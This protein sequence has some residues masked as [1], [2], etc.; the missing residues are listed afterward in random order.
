MPAHRRRLLPTLLAAGNLSGHLTVGGS[1]TSGSI[2]NTLAGAL[3]VTGNLNHLAINGNINP[4]GALTVGG[5]LGTLAIGG[6]DLGS[7]TAGSIGGI[8]VAAATPNGSGVLFSLTQG[9]SFRSITATTPLSTPAS[10]FAST[11]AGAAERRG[12]VRGL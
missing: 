3:S 5:T 8:T 7:I 12:A 1:V 9:G 2:N 10:A 4:G 6:A 11:V